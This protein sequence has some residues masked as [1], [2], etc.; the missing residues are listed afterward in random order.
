MKIYVAGKWEDREAVRE[1]QKALIDMGHEITVD[2]TYHEKDDVGYPQTYAQ[3][4]V[5]GVQEAEAYIGLFLRENNYKGALVELGVAL[6]LNKKTYI[7]GHAIDSCLF[8]SHKL[9]TQFNTVE[10][11]LDHIRQTSWTYH[12]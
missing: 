3:D 12:K 8:V 5:R 9:V 6:G 10:E 1:L 2:W 7:I 4:D 11:F